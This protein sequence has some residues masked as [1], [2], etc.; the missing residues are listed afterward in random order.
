[1]GCFAD[2][3]VVGGNGHTPVLTYLLPLVVAPVVAALF[4][5][6]AALVRRGRVYWLSTGYLLVVASLA[7]GLIAANAAKHGS[8]L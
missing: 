1:M 7:T 5:V 8:G 4:A 2:S 6:V 3:M